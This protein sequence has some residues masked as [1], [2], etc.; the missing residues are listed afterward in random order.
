MKKE[1]QDKLFEKYP[2]IFRQKDLSKQETCMC[3]GF[4]CG[5]GW[6]E[7]ID[8]LCNCIQ[9]RIDYKGGQQIEAVQVKTK[10]GG[11][12]FYTNC[13]D[14]AFILGLIRMAESMSYNIKEWT[15]K[16]K[17]LDAVERVTDQHEKT[18]TK[19]AEDGIDSDCDVTSSGK[20]K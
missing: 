6:Y 15:P 19:L 20:K 18:F 17:F 2:K 10:F 13:T 4:Q 11:L 3:W 16:E 8:A 1:L 5:D 7:L 12:R 14:D 9:S